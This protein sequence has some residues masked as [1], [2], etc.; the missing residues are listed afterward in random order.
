MGFF[1]LKR[2]MSHIYNRDSFLLY[3]LLVP[4][5]STSNIPHNLSLHSLPKKQ[6]SKRNREIVLMYPSIQKIFMEAL[7]EML[8]EGTF[9]KHSSCALG[10]V[11]NLQRMHN[12][13]SSWRTIW[14]DHFLEKHRK[15]KILL[16]WRN[17]LVSQYLNHWETS[18]WKTFFDSARDPSC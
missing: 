1:F 12:I 15:W 9:G 11:L 4:Q 18:L 3:S 5:S 16:P 8:S 10:K 13:Y 17:S 6:I 14:L 7:F 2:Y